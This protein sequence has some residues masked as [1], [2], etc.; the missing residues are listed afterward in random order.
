MGCRGLREK[1]ESDLSRR[2]E[3]KRSGRCVSSVTYVAVMAHHLLGCFVFAYNR[4]D[5]ASRHQHHASYSMPRARVA[6]GPPISNRL[7][8]V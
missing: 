2:E 3:R 7:L 6:G 8:P 1:S 4:S 5:A